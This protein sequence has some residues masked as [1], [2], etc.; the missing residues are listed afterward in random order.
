[1]VATFEEANMINHSI[2]QELH[3]HLAI[4]PIAQ[5]RQVLDFARILSITQPHGVKG[6]SLL[7]FA[8][9]IPAEELAQM[10]AAIEADCEQVDVDGW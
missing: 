3:Q 1:M 7:S 9:S 10:Q 4:L 2:E 6:S 5:Q 8:G